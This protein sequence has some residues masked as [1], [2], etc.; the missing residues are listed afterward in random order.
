MSRQKPLQLQLHL[1][2][3]PSL[4][5]LSV[6]ANGVTPVNS[7]SSDLCP[8]YDCGD[9]VVISY[10]FW[11]NNTSTSPYCG[12]PSFGLSCSPDNET[13]LRLS[14]DTYYV[15]HIN[16]ST[17]TVTL[18]DADVM[19]NSCPRVRHNISLTSLVPQL[20]YP[21]YTTSNLTFF[22]CC[23][24]FPQAYLNNYASL[25]CLIS[26]QNQSYVFSSDAIPETIDW[27]RYCK[28]KVV[29]SVMRS[30]VLDALLSNTSGFSRALQGGFEL[31]WGS[32][33]D[34]RA[35]ENSGGRCAYNTNSTKLLCICKDKTGIWKRCSDFNIF[36]EN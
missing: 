17:K 31:D 18:V 2:L 10:P 30:A 22:F 12:Y 13:I 7:T 8:S 21:N 25:S 11:Y 35:C 1:L 33:V 27:Y 26:G 32:L 4:I 6:G 36:L 28:D 20:R 16:Y 15:K 14:S 9:G 29:T 3:F 5:L 23:S 24:R 19:G 34:C